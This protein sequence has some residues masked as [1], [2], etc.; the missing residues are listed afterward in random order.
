MTRDFNGASD[1]VASTKPANKMVRMG[2]FTHFSWSNSQNYSL[3]HAHMQVVKI[4]ALSELGSRTER[5]VAPAT[6]RRKAT[7]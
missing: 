7:L 5:I 1:A 2:V 4:H 3:N 6:N